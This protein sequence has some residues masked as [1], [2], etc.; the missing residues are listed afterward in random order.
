MEA[1]SKYL[2]E[3]KV[4]F[5][6]FDRFWIENF[7]NVWHQDYGKAWSHAPLSRNLRIDLEVRRKRGQKTQSD[8]IT[9]E[10][11][12]Q[13][14]SSFYLIAFS[15]TINFTICFKTSESHIHLS[16]FLLM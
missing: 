6:Y 14:K 2:G 1:T 11:K 13:K 15:I 3:E 16:T 8:R 10:N 5:N 9:L 4:L 7:G 12:L